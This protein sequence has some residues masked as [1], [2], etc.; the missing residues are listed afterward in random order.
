MQGDVQGQ[1]VQNIYASGCTSEK[2]HLQC[3][4]SHKIAIKRI[5][6]G[7]KTDRMCRDQ[8]RNRSSDC[9]QRTH[10]D[11]I[12]M[13]DD[14]YQVLNIK[15]SGY[16][17]CDHKVKRVNSRGTCENKEQRTTDYMTIIYDCIPGSANAEFCS[18]DEKSGKLLYLSNMN[19]PSPVEKGDQYCQC[20][21]KSGY[22][23]GIAV[24]AIDIL[25]PH[26]EMEHSYKCN[27]KIQIQDTYGRTPNP[28]DFVTIYCGES[29]NRLHA[30]EQN[31]TYTTTNIPTTRSN[32]NGTALGT[33]GEPKL[34]PDM[35]AVI[36][37]ISAAAA[38][39]LLV[40]LIAIAV[41][42]TRMRENRFG[43]VKGP[44]VIPSPLLKNKHFKENGDATYH[45]YDYDEDRYCS[46]RR[47]PMKMTK[48]SDLEKESEQNLK[49]AFLQGTLPEDHPNGIPPRPPSP[50]PQLLE[51]PPTYR[52]VSD[53]KFYTMNPLKPKTEIAAIR[54]TSSLPHRGKKNKGKSVT[55]SPV[56]MVTP[57][58]S[59]SDE[60]IGSDSEKN[61]ASVI[62][63]YQNLHGNNFSPSMEKNR[64]I[65]I[66]PPTDETTEDLPPPPYISPNDNEM[67]EMEELWKSIT[68][69]ESTTLDEGAYDNIDY[70]LA[71][72]RA[73]MGQN[74]H[75]KWCTG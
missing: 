58:P 8:G 23:K 30:K 56:A 61:L 4:D 22:S 15:C 59:G 3:P 45:R 28:D 44:E 60:S 71:Q 10:R 73:N 2:I 63:T 32:I 19:Y 24:Y 18:D 43:M 52:N 72:N 47:S 68:D 25:I 26:T 6:Y 64:K 21:I 33:A 66:L 20:L 75:A 55:F 16:Q 34:I 69:A 35:V 14:Q 13:D 37:G 5:F 48:Y 51:P 40:T 29:I 74:G 62:D 54:I 67:A 17:E 53:D 41:H 36:G 42:C 7:V 38:L 27:Q 12:V 50:D 70:L 49:E 31:K 65:I 46:I 1:G 39:I 57:L 9:C 11:C